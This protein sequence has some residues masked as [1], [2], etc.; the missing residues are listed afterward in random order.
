MKVVIRHPVTK[1]F[2]RRDGGWIADWR[3]AE[4]FDDSFDGSKACSA[5]NLEAYQVMLKHLTDDSLDVIVVE[6]LPGD[7]HPGTDSRTH[8]FKHAY[9]NNGNGNGAHGSNGSL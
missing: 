9:R 7:T 5:Q 1:L 2:R 4:H 8:L 3:A 6:R